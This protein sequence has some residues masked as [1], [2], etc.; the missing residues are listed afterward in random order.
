MA[1]I[2]IFCK[3][4]SPRLHYTADWI[5]KSVLHVS[6]TITNDEEEI[7]DLPFFISY[8]ERREKA[9]SVFDYGLLWEEGVREQPIEADQ[10]NDIPVFFNGQNQNFDVSFDLFSAVFFLLSR[11]EEYYAYKPDKHNRYPAT[12]SCLY[13]NSWLERP[14]VDEWIYQLYLLLKEKDIPVQLS[15]FQYTPT[16]DIDMAYSYLHKGTRRNIAGF[17]R[18]ILKANFKAIINRKDVLLLNKLDPFDSFLYMEKLHSENNLKPI[19]FILAALK[20]TS[21]DKN[22]NPTHEVMQK[23]IKRWKKRAEIGLHP[24]YYS[25]S[26]EVLSDEKHVLES[27]VGEYVFAS[28]QHYIKVQLPTTYRHLIQKG[29]RNDYSMGY[30][31]ALG[32]RAGTGRSFNWYD[33]MLEE[34]TKLRIHPFC[35]MDS[36]AHFVLILSVEESFAALMRMKDTL[37]KTGS[38]LITIFHNFSLGNDEN[39]KGWRDAYSLF[40]RD[41]NE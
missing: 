6:Y 37:Q 13:K 15:Q 36:T 25:S 9:M 2:T 5:F 21:Y 29:I 16:Y 35:F 8:G 17:L 38:T 19:Y 23:Q 24:S 33:L 31:S 14:L 18:D 26:E 39:W 27:V 4:D 20:P 7:A 10:W 32:F 28:R 34:K 3:Q 12:E 1:A 11:Y 40:L 22:I 41:L 30:P